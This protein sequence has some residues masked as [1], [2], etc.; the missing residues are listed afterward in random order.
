MFVTTLFRLIFWLILLASVAHCKNRL[1]TATGGDTSS[2]FKVNSNVFGARNDANAIH[3]N[4]NNENSTESSR[5]EHRMSIIGVDARNGRDDIRAK[6]PN[7]LPNSSVSN[8]SSP[9]ST[10]LR[11]RQSSLTSPLVPMA[12]ESSRKASETRLDTIASTNIGNYSDQIERHRT[13]DENFERCQHKPSK[14]HSKRSKCNCKQMKFNQMQIEKIYRHKWQL[15]ERR[16]RQANNYDATLSPEMS[17]EELFGLEYAN[18]GAS[19]GPETISEY[20]NGS[21]S[22]Q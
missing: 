21:C 13:A 10:D 4:M 16:K 20:T 3:F 22:Q 5:N 8:T 7:S 11:R 15:R 9:L 17:T 18:S 19:D 6:R 14:M 1:I 2:N 12:A